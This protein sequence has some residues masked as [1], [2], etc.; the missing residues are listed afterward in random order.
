MLNEIRHALRRLRATPLVTV[1]AIAC[2]AIGVWMTCIMTAFG[3]GF[4]APNLRIPA[5]EKVVYLDERGLIGTGA[6]A[7]FTCCR[8]SSRAVID[9]LAQSRAFAASGFFVHTQSQIDGRWR[10]TI[11]LS[12]GMMGVLGV[13]PMLGRGFNPA[14]DTTGNVILLSYQMWRSMYGGDKSAIGRRVSVRRSARDSRMYT[15]IGV[16]PEDFMFPRDNER[17]DLYMVA[18][19]ATGVR[20]R[21]V[22]GLAR[23]ADGVTISEAREVARGIALR[24]VREDREAF[25]RNWRATYPKSGLPTVADGPVDVRLKRYRT[26]HIDFSSIQFILLILASGFAVVAIAAAN[27]V[28]LLLVRGASRRQEIAVRMALGASR[29]RIVRE[30]VVET[31]MV[32]MVGVAVGLFVAWRQ[33]A[34]LDPTFAGRHF[35]GDIDENVAVAAVVAGALLTIVVGV[36]PGLRATSL[37]LEHVLRDARRSGIGRSP[38]DGVLGRL[39]AVSTAGT[40]MLLITAVMLTLSARDTAF[41]FGLGRR[42]L[43]TVDLSLQDDV[44]AARTAV[45]QSALDRVRGVAGVSTAAYGMVPPAAAN[46]PLHITVVGGVETLYSSVDM[47]SVSDAYFKTV[48]LPLSEG[49]EFTPREAK[50]SSGV[51]IVSRSLAQRLFPGRHAL[52]EHIWLRGEEPSRTEV[53]I[54]GI[55]ENARDGRTAGQVYLPFANAAPIQAPL[56]VKPKAGA[57]PDLH[58]ALRSIPRL[59]AGPAMTAERRA[60][61]FSPVPRYLMIAFG[62]FA[63][64]ALALA[65]IGTY[66]VVSYSVVR[67]THEIG[68]RMALG[69]P[70]RR[71]TWMI[72]EQ[73]LKIS[74]LGVGAGLLLSFIVI[75]VIGRYLEDVNT[76]YPIA[77]AA[78]VGFVSIVSVV[79][80]G[81]PGFRAGRLNPVDALRAE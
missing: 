79:A 75:R 19:L 10:S 52:G 69:A 37:S 46:Q 49:R 67:R 3:R 74:L 1:S 50:D 66:G 57:K 28:N 42:D 11:L 25:L 47:H 26:G 4:F 2:L 78:V 45:A 14:D 41:Q 22:T 39:V 8:Y 18:P 12:S 33:W 76:N 61:G 55:A 35:F 63:V 60:N 16:M 48:S 29:Y 23:V 7:F 27:V 5:P 17:P 51:V 70:S 62:M 54:V 13:R 58:S 38:L 40:V 64:V 31:A 34:L 21:I 59:T 77:I 20:D 15:V 65:A 72:V 71:V 73:G 53:V 30:L 68:V 32:A 24:N 43:V 56:V 6:R 80:S 9:S 81:I 36:W 44:A